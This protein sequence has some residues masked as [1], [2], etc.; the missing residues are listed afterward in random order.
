[1]AGR[2][3]HGGRYKKRNTVEI[4]RE[5]SYERVR[6]GRCVAEFGRIDVVVRLLDI[7]S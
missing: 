6:R 2:Q 7:S 1:L 5:V 3:T 4:E